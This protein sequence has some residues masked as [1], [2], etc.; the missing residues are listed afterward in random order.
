[1]CCKKSRRESRSFANIEKAGFEVFDLTCPDV[2]KV[3][4]KAIELVKDGYF[5]VIVGK[6]SHPEV[7]AIKANAEQ[8]SKNVLVATDVDQLK[9]FEKRIE[10]SKENRCCC[11][12]NSDDF[13][14]T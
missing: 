5:L 6:A 10:K 14:I 3:Q 13:D 4:Q 12:N 8:Y 9:P 2:K 7:V 1:M 11:S